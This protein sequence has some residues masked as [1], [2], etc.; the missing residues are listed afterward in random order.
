M[1]KTPSPCIDVCKFKRDGHCI[2]CSMTKAQKALFK[3][4]KRNRHRKTFVEILIAQQR[5]M[6]GYGH[7]VSQYQR[8]CLKK[9]VKP[10]PAVHRAAKKGAREGAFPESWQSFLSADGCAETRQTFHVSDPARCTDPRSA[11]RRGRQP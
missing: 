10:I 2:G 7:W 11:Y 8:K 1:A 3:D 4:L 5:T 6:G 9:K